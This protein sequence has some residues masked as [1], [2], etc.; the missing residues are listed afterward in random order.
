MHNLRVIFTCGPNLRRCRAKPSTKIKI[1]SRAVTSKDEFANE[2]GD[3]LDIPAGRLQV[4][5]FS[6]STKAVFAVEDTKNSVEEGVV[7]CEE[8]EVASDVVA[9]LFGP[10]F[11]NG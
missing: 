11:T 9:S 2:V 1:F 4:L 6:D 5:P 7:I 10:A 3:F 8:G